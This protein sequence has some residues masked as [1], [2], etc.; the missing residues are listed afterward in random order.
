M[1]VKCKNESE[2]L[3]NKEESK[4]ERK[5]VT[6]GLTVKH[7]TVFY[8]GL[9]LGVQ[10]PISLSSLPKKQSPYYCPIISLICY[11]SNDVEFNNNIN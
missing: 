7:S 1:R 8:G 6:V 11:F 4:K 9:K 10:W 3:K 5:S 2:K